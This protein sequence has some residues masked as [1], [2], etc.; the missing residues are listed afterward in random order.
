MR[1]LLVEVFNEGAVGFFLDV[2]GCAVGGR[3]DG[4]P[5]HMYA[6]EC[7]PLETDNSKVV[8]SCPGT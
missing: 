6:R 8:S 5:S 3:E 4:P 2:R 7:R 1:V